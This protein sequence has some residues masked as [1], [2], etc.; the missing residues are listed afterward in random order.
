MSKRIYLSREHA[1]NNMLWRKEFKITFYFEQPFVIVRYGFSYERHMKAG[2]IWRRYLK[3]A[4]RNA[5]NGI[6]AHDFEIK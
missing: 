2:S 1:Y 5:G 4:Y 3:H 6:N